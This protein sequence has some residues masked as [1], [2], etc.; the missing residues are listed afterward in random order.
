VHE[1]FRDADDNSRIIAV[2]D[3]TVDRPHRSPPG[4]NYGTYFSKSEIEDLLAEAIITGNAPPELSRTAGRHGT[5]V[6]SIAAGRA[7]GA[8]AGGMAPEAKIVVVIA[9]TGELP[10]SNAYV[11]ALK[12][13]EEVTRPTQLPVVVN[14]SGGTPLGA[15]DGTSNVEVAFDTF[16]QYGTRQGMIVVKSAGNDYGERRH[17]RLSIPAGSREMLVW[18]TPGGNHLQDTV[19][20]WF[21]PS[22]TFE[23]RL[24]STMSPSPWVKPHTQAKGYFMSGNQY[25]VFYQHLHHYNGGNYLIAAV[26]PGQAP[27]IQPGDYAL[28]IVN[29]GP[30]S[31]PIDAWVDWTR[32]ER[33]AFV[34]HHRDETT[35]SVPGTAHSV[36]CVGAVHTATPLQIYFHS[37]EGRTR[38]G[39]EKP[40]LA[41]PGVQINAASANTLND[42]EPFDGTSQAAAHVSGAVALLLSHWEKLRGADPAS[43]PLSAT[44]VRWALILSAQNYSRT[45]HS[46]MGYGVLDARALLN[47]F[48]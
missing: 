37:S 39:R 18:S 25:E 46:R 45:W 43:R 24:H 4:F 38:D 31:A 2:W 30:A 28:E 17:A 14:L 33:L 20:L 47:A 23:F 27:Y 15:H 34:N 26:R 1:S 35:L 9:K 5:H 32:N 21:H 48:P 44:Q 13:I 42:V 8:F 3:Q 16:T 29:P 22:D 19:E 10:G 6:A 40:D 36:I 7:A 11:D 12:F 41:A